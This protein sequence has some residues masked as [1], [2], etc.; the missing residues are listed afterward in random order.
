MGDYPDDTS[1]MQIIGSDIMVPIDLQA[2]YIMMPVDI[3]AQYL[4][5]EI[6]IVAQSVGDITVDIAAQSIGNLA[7]NI[8]ASAITLDIN[9]ASSDITLNVDIKAQTIATLA[10]DIDAQSVA[11]IDQPNWAAINATDKNFTTNA[12]SKTFGQNSYGT[13]TVPTGKKL[14]M[15]GMS[16]GINAT[17]GTD[18]DLNQVGACY[19]QNV[20]TGIYIGWVGGNGGGGITFPK[21]IP[22]S[23]NQQLYYSVV[24]FANHTVNIWMTCWG[25]EL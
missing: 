15:C 12:G 22:I 25:Y 9:V 21:P 3:Q 1:L 4:T 19:L 18:G 5:L 13:Y 6:D 17:S 23:A 14:Y 11:I 8:A 7:V 20:T 16:F 10:I 2:A 24:T